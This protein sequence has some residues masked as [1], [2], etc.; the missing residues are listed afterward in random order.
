MV[1]GAQQGVRKAEKSQ[2]HEPDRVQD[3]RR[4][5]HSSLRSPGAVQ[6]LAFGFC[7]DGTVDKTIVQAGA[8]WLRSSQTWGTPAARLC[9]NVINS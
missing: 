7:L 9:A 2:K 1:T 4:L 8:G 5:P 6:L 3:P